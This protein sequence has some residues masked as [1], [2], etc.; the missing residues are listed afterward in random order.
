MDRSQ[1]AQVANMVFSHL[2]PLSVYYRVAVGLVQSVYGGLGSVTGT[3][4]PD[5]AYVCSHG[6]IK[7]R[8]LWAYCGVS[9][10]DSRSACP[11]HITPTAECDTLGCPTALLSAAD[12]VVVRCPWQVGFLHG[13]QLE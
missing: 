5:E 6:G 4:R 8:L 10:T 12:W 13:V 9:V 7:Y 1:V 11:Q 3:C 2:S